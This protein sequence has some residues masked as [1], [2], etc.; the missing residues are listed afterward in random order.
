MTSSNVTSRR[1][2]ATSLFMS[3]RNPDT[4]LR[5]AVLRP[6]DALPLDRAA[7]VERFS[8][9]IDPDTRT[10]LPLF[11]CQRALLI[12]F[13]SVCNLHVAFHFLWLGG[14]NCVL[15]VPAWPSS[16]YPTRLTR[17]SQ[18]NR[19]KECRRDSWSRVPV[20]WRHHAF[21]TNFKNNFF[22]FRYLHPISGCVIWG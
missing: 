6:N 1:G 16:R 13:T 15:S 3:R 19:N 22:S 21:G 11:D 12:A 20:Y 9:A 17:T 8:P 14:T 5:A 2:T 7:A 18:N 4:A 10:V